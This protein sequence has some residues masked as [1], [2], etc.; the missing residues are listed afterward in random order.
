MSY[1]HERV[2]SGRKGRGTMTTKDLQR[3]DELVHSADMAVRVA[4]QLRLWIKRRSLRDRDAVDEGIRFLEEAVRGG[5][6]VETG[7]LVA[8]SSTS[9]YPL[10]WSADVRFGPT[11]QLVSSSPAVVKYDELLAFLDDTKETLVGVAADKSPADNSVNA[12]ANFF[13]QLGQF[14][15][16]K[17]D[18]A[19]RSP[20][21]GTQLLHDRFSYQRSSTSSAASCSTLDL[22]SIAL[23]E[24]CRGWRR[25]I[26][27]ATLPR[28]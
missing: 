25:T 14:L 7:E 15:G 6:F 24:P 8:G 12:A 18:N 5:K 2:S 27:P 3:I 16:S 13:R 23:K 9:L 22:S 20:A 17:A 21:G 19:L 4:S 10:N 11:G 28:F 1:L 26:S